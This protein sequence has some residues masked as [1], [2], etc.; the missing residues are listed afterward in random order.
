MRSHARLATL[1][2][3]VGLIGTAIAE[4]PR[5]S[6]D[7]QGEKILHCYRQTARFE[8]AVAIAEADVLAKGR[9]GRSPE[10]HDR[11]A[12]VERYGEASISY[13]RIYWRG[14]ISG[15]SHVSDVAVLARSRSGRTEYRTELLAD[16]GVV[17]VVPRV[18]KAATG[19]VPP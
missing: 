18:C 2:L 4:E 1:A 12:L 6:A 19:W 3:A 17:P 16:T 7:L 14:G 11:R 13:L 8:K 9:F 5:P 10:P 15:A